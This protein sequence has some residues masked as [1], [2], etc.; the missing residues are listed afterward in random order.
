MFPLYEIEF[1]PKIA[2]GHG[3]AHGPGSKCPLLCAKAMCRG[4]AD[5]GGHTFNRGL[6]QLAYNKERE[7][8]EPVE[9]TMNKYKTG[10]K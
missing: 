4:A 3:R 1:F 2:R 5:A 10:G 6:N 8:G 9:E 7:F